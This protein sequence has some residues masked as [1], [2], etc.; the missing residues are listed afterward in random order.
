MAP[1]MTT[2]KG[3]ALDRAA[4]DSLLRRRFFFAPTAELYG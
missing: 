4:V 3:Q 1:E 2:L